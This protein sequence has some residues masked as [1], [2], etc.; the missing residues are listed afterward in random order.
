[1]REALELN[2]AA[3]QV[4]CCID[5]APRESDLIN[6][7]GGKSYSIKEILDMADN[8]LSAPGGDVELP[9]PVVVIGSGFTAF[10]IGAGPIAPIIERNNI[11]VGDK[12][13][14]SA[15]AQAYGDAR[16]EAAAA[17]WIEQHGRDS[18]MLRQLCQ[19]RDDAKRATQ[20]ERDCLDAAKERIADLERQLS[21]AKSR[22]FGQQIY[23]VPK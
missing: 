3:L 15:K 23:K 20:H 12:L 21:E 5:R 13:V 19:E 2:A 4:V 9:E 16:A 10:W 18:A 1:M 17:K 8:A 7:D 6:R 11:K 22:Q 14:T